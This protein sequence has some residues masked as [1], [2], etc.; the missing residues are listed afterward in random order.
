MDARSG[1]PAAKREP[2]PEGLG[3]N[4]EYDLSAVGAALNLAAR[5]YVI[6]SAAGGSAVSSAP[7][8]PLDEGCGLNRKSVGG[9]TSASAAKQAA[10][11]AAVANRKRPS[12]A[13]AGP[14]FNQ[15]R[16]G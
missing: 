9:L 15:L 3:L 12:A 4:S 2:S 14:I 10:E 5:T 1:G 6:R 11:K 8:Q 7:Q 13:K 16:T